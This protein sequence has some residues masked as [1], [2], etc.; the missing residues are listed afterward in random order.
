MFK[1]V[2]WRR[3]SYSQGLDQN[4][5][6]LANVKG[7]IGVRDSKDPGGPHLVFSAED[8]RLLTVDLRGDGANPAP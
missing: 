2:P 1:D 8:I 7:V 6:E 3:S 4:C 5:V